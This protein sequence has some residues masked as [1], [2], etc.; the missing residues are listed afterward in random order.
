MKKFLLVILSFILALLPLL[1]FPV[2][3]NAQESFKTY[4]NVSY[5]VSERGETTVTKHITLENLY[6]NIY[7]TSYVVTLDGLNIKDPKA[8]QDGRELKLSQ[9]QDGSKI[10]LKVEFDDAVVGKG[11]RRVFSIVFRDD[12]I[13]TK[14]GEVWEVLIPKVNSDT[15]YEGYGVDLKIPLSFGEKAYMTPSP[16]SSSVA[17]IYNQYSFSGDS[18]ANFGVSAAFGKF[19]VFDFSLTYH[20]ENPL[21]RSE[22][23]DVAIPPDTAYQK[24]IYKE[25]T[26]KPSLVT[27]DEDGNWIASFNLR[28]R[29]R[30][31]VKASG[32]VQIF[33]SGRQFT[34]P[35]S[36]TIMDNL[37]ASEFWQI[38]SP[39]IKSFAGKYRTP[40]AIYDYVVGNLSYDYDRVKPNVVR[41]GA[42]AVLINPKSAICTEFTDL[43]IAMARAAGIPAREINGYAYTENPE[44]QPLSLVADVLHAWPEYWDAKK[45]IWIP[46]DPTWGQTTGGIDFF[47]NLDLR[48]FT[49]VIHGS[50]ATKPY[51]PGSYKL[52]ANPQKDVFVSFG[53]LP[54]KRTSVPAVKTKTSGGILFLKLK[55]NIEIDN[56]GPVGLYDQTATVYF[57]SKVQKTLNL[58]P[59]PVYGKDSF[60]VNVP[61]GFFGQGTPDNVTI[62][63]GGEKVTIPTHKNNFVIANVS[64]VLVILFGITLVTY[65]RIRNFLIRRRG[66]GKKSKE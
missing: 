57:D 6:S 51:P 42:L 21:P 13:I 41:I 40:R 66:G 5:V 34:P 46:V 60:E 25:I 26:P 50:S 10:T 52:G 15:Q 17:G 12:S 62:L 48:H 14:T 54:E 28:A 22:S 65:F 8:Y 55:L 23:V 29:E 3:V 47:N 64:I 63:V 7:A 38:D 53:T 1:N 45:R 44:I 4:L 24:V 2:E 20:L 58:D 31:D 19:Q 32:S 11:K 9:K 35:T 30:V 59:I 37:K 56:P 33:A 18:V 43:F 27:V 16:E 36:Q 39:E 61:Y 49:F